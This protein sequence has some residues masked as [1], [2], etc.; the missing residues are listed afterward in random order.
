MPYVE[1]HTCSAFSFL[2]GSL[3][4]EVL[5]E[6]AARLDYPAL[7]LLDRD[8]VYG[9]PRFYKACKEAK[10]RPLVGTEITLQG[11]IHRLP[12]LVETQKGY[13]NLCRLITRMKLRSKKSAG[14]VGLSELEEFAS[15]LVC[16]T[17]GGNGPLPAIL[18]QGGD[19]KAFQ[20]LQQLRKIFGPDGVFI[21]LQ[22]HFDRRQEAY[23]QTYIELAKRLHLPLLATNGVC[24]ARASDRSLLDVLTCIRHKTTLDEAGKLLN[25]NAEHYLKTPKEMNRLFADLPEALAV[26]VELSQRLDFTLDNLDYR[27]PEY[28][29]PSGENMN[30]YLRKLTEKGARQRYR[31]YHQRARRQIVRELNLIEKLD[32]AGYFL[33]VWDIVC[34]CRKQDILVQG[35]GSAANSAVCYSLGITAVDPVSMDLLFERFLSEERGEWP[36]IDLDLPSGERRE[37]VIQYLY[38]CYGKHGAAMTA[39]VVTYRGR[40]AVREVGKVLGFSP[41]TL[42]RLSRLL[43]TWGWES[44]EEIAVERFKEVDLNLSLPRVKKFLQLWKR[45]QDIPRHLS[46]HSGGMVIAQGRLD[47]VVPL[48]NATMPGRTVVQ[49]DKEDCADLGIIKVDLLGLGMMSVLQDSLQLVSHCGSELDLPHLPP[50]DPEVYAMLQKADTVGVFQVESRA[51]M[52][53]L[54]RLR[55]RC[56]YDLVV[57]LAIIRPGPIVGQMVNPYLKRRTGLEPVTYPHPSLEPILKRTLGVP[58][59]QEQLL[60]I[61]MVVAGFSGGE[62]EEL[63]RALGFRR[64]QARMQKIEARLRQGMERNGI[65]GEAAE[66]IVR[67]ITSFALYGFPESHSASFALLSYASAY[68]KVHFSAAFYAALL[69]NQ[70]MG[71]YHPATLVKD[72]QRHH[73]LIKPIDV[74]ESDWL[75]TI[76]DGG[77]VRLGLMYVWGLRQE[78][79]KA[80]ERERRKKP[81]LSLDDLWKLAG[82]RKLEMTTLAEIGALKG[83]GM[84]RRE[85]LWQVEKVCRSSGPLFSQLESSGQEEESPLLDM[86]TGERL[87]ADYGGTGLTLGSHP[88]ALCR[89]ELTHKGVFCASELIR[90]RHGCWVRVAGG[91]IVR[92]RPSTAQGVFFI[93]LED[94]TGIANV[95]IRPQLFER[96]RLLLVNQPFLMVEGTLQNQNNVTSIRAENIR[97]IKGLTP[98]IS[99]HDFR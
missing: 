88:L 23:N 64:S 22:R 50:D 68:L 32:L 75:C 39:N 30:S 67:Y 7:A 84:K 92:Q 82:L 47:S 18:D 10:L 44:P 9:A 49:W 12:L 45:I 62:A 8:G 55:P 87:M 85:A 89:L 72:A 54:P 16:L 6:E 13:Q 99:S 24:Y 97:P 61:A 69:N 21:E 37:R 93:S 59:F 65:R 71:F 73:Q 14:Q 95:V 4:P 17:G 81:F 34:F 70:P 56:F 96:K 46:Q 80:I 91:V 40:S 77:S 60:R 1:L 52:V 48:E 83:F 2:E 58:L 36:D 76:E 31:P 15:G 98:A 26:T 28:S 3:L 38:E 90:L 79:G 11:G 53:T 51:Q 35:R 29:V 25:R 63:R 66:T 74:L 33:I 43:N 19:Q 5:V 57:E 20:Y 86:T 42:D 27:F 41:H 78:V 94:E